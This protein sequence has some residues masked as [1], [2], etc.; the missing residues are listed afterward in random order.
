MSP[1]LFPSVISPC[2]DKNKPTNQPKITHKTKT[3]TKHTQTN[4]PTNQLHHTANYCTN[5]NGRCLWSRSELN[6][7][8]LVILVLPCIYLVLSLYILGAQIKISLL[9]IIFFIKRLHF[10][11]CRMYSIQLMSSLSVTYSFVLFYW[12]SSTLYK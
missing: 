10:S 8:L 11:G 4:Q 7:P 6:H 12:S 1:I 2:R 3:K 9:H 5:L